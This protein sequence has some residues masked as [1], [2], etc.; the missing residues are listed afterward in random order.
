ME[1]IAWLIAKIKAVMV[2]LLVLAAM[3]VICGCA[4]DRLL[5]QMDNAR[6]LGLEDKVNYTAPDNVGE[7]AD[8]TP[9]P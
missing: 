1:I 9:T 6:T 2:L 7:C 8:C 3:A 4:V 5:L